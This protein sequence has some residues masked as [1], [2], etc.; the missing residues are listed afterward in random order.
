[1]E[2]IEAL[3]FAPKM[4]NIKPSRFGSLRV[5][6][7]GYDYVAE[8][9]IGAYSGGQFELGAG[10]GQAQYLSSLFHPDGPNDLAPGGYDDPEPAPGLPESPLPVT[11]SPTGFRWIT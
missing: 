8:H 3:P 6:F 1:M 5:L 9:G 4:V 11:A 7:R 2:D 10:R